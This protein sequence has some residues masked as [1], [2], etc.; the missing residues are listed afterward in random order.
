MRYLIAGGAGFIGSN[1][2]NTL[3]ADHEV[4]AVD[5]ELLGDRSNLD[6]DVDFRKQNVLDDDLPTDVDAIFH[7]AGLSSYAMHE[8]SPQRGVRTNVEGFVNV[9][10]QARKDGCDTIVYAS[11]SSVYSNH[12]EPVPE[13]RSVTANTGYEASKLARE[14]YAEYFS[15]HYGMS[16]AGMRFFSVYEGYNGLEEHKGDYANVVA[17]FADAIANGQ[18]PVLYGDGSQTRDFIHVDDIV[19]GLI[20]A[21][22]NQIDGVFNLGTGDS[23]SFNTVVEHINAEFETAIQPTYVECPIPKSVYVHDTCADHT[24]LTELTGWEPQIPFRDG[25][26]RVCNEYKLEKSPS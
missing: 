23:V 11:T 24:R 15:N 7:L 16:L 5:T 20:K 6:A 19:H 4:I 22:Q 8:E 26:K 18:S 2:A 12:T 3:A 25:I 21:A 14:K 9:V 1:L 13:S 17:Q 10:E